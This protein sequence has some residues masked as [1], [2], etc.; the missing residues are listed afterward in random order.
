MQITYILIRCNIMIQVLIIQDS[1]H[2]PCGTEDVASV[3]HRDLR[4]ME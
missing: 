3:V 4:A 2:E 1:H